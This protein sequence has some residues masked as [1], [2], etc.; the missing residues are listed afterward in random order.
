[1]D[2][3]IRDIG[4]LTRAVDIRNRGAGTGKMAEIVDGATMAVIMGRADGEITEVRK[5]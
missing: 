1:M 5:Y 3:V 2:G 4:I